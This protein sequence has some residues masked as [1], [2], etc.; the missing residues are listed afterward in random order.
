MRKTIANARTAQ[1]LF[2]AL[3]RGTGIALAGALLAMVQP[4]ALIFDAHHGLIGMA[5]ADEGGGEGEG[6]GESGGANGSDRQH[7]PVTTRHDGPSALARFLDVLKQQGSVTS[8]RTGAGNIVVRYSD[9]WA[10]QIIG[11][12]YSLLDRTG[13]PVIE[14]P[15]NDTDFKRLKAAEGR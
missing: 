3:G 9:G 4:S 13:R 1:G 14:R 10:E 15:A 6:E 12:T 5:H 8:S 7:Q 11:G 2:R